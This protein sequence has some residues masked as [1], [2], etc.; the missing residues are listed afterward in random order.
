MIMT[1]YTVFFCLM[2]FPFVCDAVSFRCEPT[3][4]LINEHLDK[5]YYELSIQPYD[6]LNVV[7]IGVKL[8]SKYQKLPFSELVIR[9]KEEDKVVFFAQLTTRLLEQKISTSFIIDE[10]DLSEYELMV[11]YKD[12]KSP[13]VESKGFI[14]RVDSAL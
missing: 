5:K 10:N 13:C 4:D 11:L 7:Y 2:F 9:R 1:K 8:D 6:G 14:V 12:Y 3:E